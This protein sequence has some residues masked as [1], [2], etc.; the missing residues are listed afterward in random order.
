MQC[1]KCYYNALI[2]IILVIYDCSCI[3]HVSNNKK[4]FILSQI[5]RLS[6]ILLWVTDG[7]NDTLHRELNT[8]DESLTSALIKVC[9]SSTDP[10]SQAH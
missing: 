7:C 4:Y 9:H 5:E 6:L 1:N 2:S 3:I 10:Q 8:A